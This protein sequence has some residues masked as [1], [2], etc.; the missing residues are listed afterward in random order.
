MLTVAVDENIPLLPAALA[1]VASVWTFSAR[2]LERSDLMGTDVLL[3]RSKTRVNAHLLEGT[4]VRFVG[5]ATAGTDHLDTNWLSSQGITIADAAGCNANSV[6]EYVLFAALL[7][8][9]KRDEPLRGKTIGIV[10]FGNVGRRV[11]ELAH[12][13]SMRVL[14]SDPP[15]SNSQYIFP[16]YGLHTDLFHLTATSDIVTVHVPLVHSRPY[17]TAHLFSSLLLQ[18]LRSGVLFIQTSR[19][20]V[21]D[22]AALLPVLASQRF[23]A[24]LDVWEQEPLVDTQLAQSCLLAT[25]HIA[26]YAWEGKVRGAEMMAAAFA[27][28]SGMQ[29]DETVFTEAWQAAASPEIADGDEAGLRVLLRERRRLDDDDKA[30]RETFSLAPEERARLFDELRRQYPRRHESLLV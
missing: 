8:S 3:V 10:G 16:D 26:G 2:K 6:A 29:P 27:R 22:E 28:W 19:G 9:E 18:L 24:V 17:P 1:P 13:L 12:R 21:A 4:P 23:T 11:A 25:P 30:F 15:L 7:W 5:T 20:G 14:V